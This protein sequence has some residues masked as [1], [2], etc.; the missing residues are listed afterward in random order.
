MAAIKYKKFFNLDAVIKSIEAYLPGF[1][2]KRF[3][4]AFNFAEKAHKNQFRKDVKTPYIAH[5]VE[6]VKI[7]TT[8]H[9]DED[10][11]ISALYMTFLK[12]QNMIFKKFALY[13]VIK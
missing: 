7:L 4:S 12:I 2:K 6:T 13:L 5:P 10:T 11:L 8:L 9:A 1:D 3:L